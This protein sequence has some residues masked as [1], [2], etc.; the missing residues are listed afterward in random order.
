MFR[1][2][3]SVVKWILAGQ[4]VSSTQITTIVN[5]SL[6]YYTYE[7]DKMSLTNG[8]HITRGK[9]QSI[10]SCVPFIWMYKYAIE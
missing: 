8:N 3:N 5:T 10:L 4:G 1:H 6:Y 7:A 2:A 9:L